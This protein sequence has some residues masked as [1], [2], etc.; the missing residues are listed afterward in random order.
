MLVALPQGDDLLRVHYN[1][2]LTSIDKRK[3]RTRKLT[4]LRMAVV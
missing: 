4:D 3:G 2:E 1:T